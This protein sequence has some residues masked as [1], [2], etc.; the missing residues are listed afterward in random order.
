MV[1]LSTVAT[2]VPIYTHEGAKAVK[3]NYEKQLRRS[4][5]ACLLWEDEFYE[6]GATIADR[7]AYLVPK[8]KPA[9]VAEIAIEAREKMN[10]RHVPLLIVREMA[11]SSKHK[12]LVK[13]TLEMIIKRA[14]ELYEFVALYW[15]DKKQPLSAQ[16][17]KGLANAFVKFDAYQLAKYNRDYTIKLRDVLFLCHAKPKDATQAA[18][19]KQLVDN[20]LK[21][22][23]TWEVG[24][25]AGKDK[26]S[27]FER[28]MKANKLGAMALLRNLRNM[29]Q[30]GVDTSLIVDALDVANYSRVLPFRF[31]TAAKHN[32]KLEHPIEKAYFKCTEQRD[33]LA[34]K[35]ILVV[36]VSG[37][38]YG[39]TISKFSELDR[40]QVASSVAVLAREL[41][42]DVSIYAT[43]G[44]D[45]SRVHATAEVPA[46]RGFALSD[47]VHNMTDKLGGGGIFLTQT[48]DYIKLIEKSADRIIVI[49]DEQDCDND[50]S[51]SPSKADAFGKHNYLINVASAENG[52]GY[53]PKWHHIDGFSA[54]VFDYIK[55]YEDGGF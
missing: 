6:S 47:V 13:D 35:T 22:P 25:S 39:G 27:T 24:L 8:V 36:D 48:L 3:V 20:N 18:V 49:T 33:K 11:R 42:D 17:K 37:S 45:S 44:N 40:A 26:K 2:T 4:V 12:H 9:E 5:M 32:P 54:A 50:A 28:L 30:A 38:M 23:D 7:I 1:K 41:C 34:G 52:I 55:A 10:L 21:S 53:T 43:A 51:R 14:D 46:R 31:I 29:T 19:W 16:V 15:K